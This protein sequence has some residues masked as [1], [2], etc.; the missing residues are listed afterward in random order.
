MSRWTLRLWFY[1][2]ANLLGCALALVGPLLR[3]LGWINAGWLWI[4][5]GLYGAGFLLAPRSPELTRQIADN[6]SAEDTLAQLDALIQQ[7]QPHM[8]AAMQGH[9]MHIRTAVQS[10]LPRLGGGGHAH[11]YTVRETVL[12]YLPE[13][14]ANY[15]ALPVVFRTQHTLADGQTARQ[16]LT[17]QLALLDRTLQQIANDLAHDDAQALLAN[18]RFLQ[19]RFGR[20]EFLPR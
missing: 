17:A 14:L 9:L 16:I 18:D 7:A 12:R 6:L 19:A 8:D 4:T 15:V 2:N 13:T 11:S 5:L 20:P 1:S 3:G 10:V